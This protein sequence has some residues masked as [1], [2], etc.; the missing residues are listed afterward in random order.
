MSGTE[1][2]ANQWF[3]FIVTLFVV[4]ILLY[5][6]N[7]GLLK[8]NSA[9]SQTQ[10]L[11][12]QLAMLL[13]IVIALVVI[14]LALPV[15]ESSRNQVLALLGIVL[16]GLIAF[17]S[18]SIVA[19]LMAGLVI[20][21]NRPFRTGD[22][23]ICEHI[24]GRVT[25]KGILD[26]EIQTEQRTLFSVANSFLINHPVEVVR[27]SGILISAELSLGYDVHHSVITEHLIDAA[28]ETGLTDAF[29]NV[30]QLNDFSVSY[31][32]YGFLSDTKS[33]LSTRSKLLRKILD[34]LHQND[35][36]I[37]SP[38][39]IAQRPTNAEAKYIAKPIGILK[40][41]ETNE[42]V[43]EDIAFDKAEQAEKSEQKLA[44]AQAKLVK[45]KEQ[46]QDAEQDEKQALKDK[47]EDLQK[48][49]DS[50]SV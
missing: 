38:N 7:W 5:L 45:L 48:K 34:T 26:T 23:I 42:T 3:V 28:T 50:M 25:E 24:S 29:T 4:A 11:P 15:S 2:I 41:A 39:F 22:Y 43:Q 6:I 46:L 12:L 40:Q 27:S 17:S 18:A 8:R 47:L 49:I 44:N 32:V 9:S 36:E 20:R 30:T 37:L 33:M 35:I 31:K 13:C 21:L 10:K 16:S 1:L 19:N 14:I